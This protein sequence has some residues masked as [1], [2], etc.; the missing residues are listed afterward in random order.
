MAAA[1]GL[2]PAAALAHDAG[3]VYAR[4]S[5]PGNDAPVQE[6]LTMTAATL[7][8]L[9]PVDADGDGKLTQADLDARSEAILA[10]VWNAAP[11]SA[12]GA[13]C[14]PGPA[15]ARLGDGFVELSAGFQCGPGELSQTFKLLEVL[16]PAYRVVLGYEVA[17]QVGQRFAQGNTQTLVLA[18]PRGQGAERVSGF[19]G[20]FRLG[21]FHI[22][23]GVDHLAF[24]AALLL[25]GKRWKRVLWMVTAFTLAHSITLGASALDLI[26]LSSRSARWVECLI[27][28]SIVWVAVENLVLRDPRH[29]AF[30]AFGFGLVHG[31]GFA[32]VLKSYGLGGS[33]VTGLLGFN[34]GVEAGQACVVLA[35]FPLI[36][37]AHR[38]PAVSTWV[39]RFASVVILAA[40]GTWL[41]ERALG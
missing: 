19:P 28:L 39:V 13:P 9:A 2:A 20:W 25:V 17:G 22:F 35:I 30:L 1:L 31:F 37:W 15:R 23:T 16:P 26:P 6:T 27:A 11:L 10:G 4:V 33:V 3:L 7:A 34:L 5:R 21:V 38:R 14:R 36:Q 12:Q 18:T 24:L 41:V 29:R 32:S 40:G 8:R